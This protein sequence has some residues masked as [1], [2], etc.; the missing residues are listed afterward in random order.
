LSGRIYLLCQLPFH[1]DKII[2]LQEGRREEGREKERMKGK[3]KGRMKR[4]ETDEH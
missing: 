4:G 3:E 1:S 2:H